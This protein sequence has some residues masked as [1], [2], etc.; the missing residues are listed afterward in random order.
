MPIATTD[1]RSLFDEPM[2]AHCQPLR[3]PGPDLTAA[4]NAR[5]SNQ[6]H[7]VF[8][9]MKSGEWH[10]LKEIATATGTPEASASAQLRHARKA[11]FGGH[12]LER[13]HVG[14]GLYKYRLLVNTESQ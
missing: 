11:R 5:L 10:T 12:R 14:G 6:F 4:D 9:F 8:E 2:P 7:R 13:E 1:Q 3:F